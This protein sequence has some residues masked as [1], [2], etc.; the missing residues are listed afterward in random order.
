MSA[1]TTTL[2]VQ[3]YPKSILHE[4][5]QLNGGTPIFLVEPVTLANS[6][7]PRFRCTLTCPAV[8]N[9]SGSFEQ[10]V[11]VAE[12]RAKK[13]AEHEAASIALNFLLERNMLPPDAQVAVAPPLAAAV[14]LGAGGMS[15]EVICQSLQA[16]GVIAARTAVAQPPPAGNLS[17]VER[18]TDQ[19][20]RSCTREELEEMLKRARIS[21][22]SMRARLN[23]TEQTL[24][25]VTQTTIH[26]NEHA[27]QIVQPS[28]PE[29]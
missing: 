3:K 19:E 9:R 5:Y 29:T 21:F 1:G 11:F 24:L 12:A 4:F 14:A 25:N 2:L 8:T 20:I 28:E 15:M 18:V 17:E 22:R 10:Q 26:V 23:L 7:E 27:R 13:G 16:L 6:T